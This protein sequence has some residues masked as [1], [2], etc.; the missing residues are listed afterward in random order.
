[1]TDPADTNSTKTTKRLPWYAMTIIVFAIVAL[2]TIVGF[3]ATGIIGL[4]TMPGSEIPEAAPIEYK[5]PYRI[6]SNIPYKLSNQIRISA[7]KRDSKHLMRFIHADVLQHGGELV[8][9]GPKNRH[10]YHVSSKY[11]QRLQPLFTPAAS[12]HPLPYQQWVKLPQDHAATNIE[13]DTEVTISVSTTLTLRTSFAI[14]FI[15]LS[16]VLAVSVFGVILTAGVAT[17]TKL[18]AQDRRSK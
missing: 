14:T 11:V 17:A 16:A 18:D 4:V 9:L 15:I 13:N 1:M 3:I 6:I 8:Q 7:P 5:P 10:T 2:L 12:D